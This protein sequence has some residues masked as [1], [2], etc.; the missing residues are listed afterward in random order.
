[1]GT[2]INPGNEAFK[3]IRNG[4]Y[5]DKSGLIKCVN[6]S[7]D[8][9]NKLTCVSRSRRF[10]KSLA[11]QMLCAYYDR[12]VDSESLFYDLEISKS[13]DYHKY[14]NKYDVIYLDISGFISE[15][16]SDREEITHISRRIKDSIRAELMVMDAEIPPE[17]DVN[18]GL[19]WYCRKTGRK[20]IFI[21]DEWDAVIREARKDIQTQDSY[22]GL[23][24]GWFKNGNFTPYAVAAAYMTGILPIKKDGSQSAIS[25]FREYTMTDP[26]IME[27]YTGFLQNEVDNIC[28]RYGVSAEDMKNWYDGYEFG[29]SGA[30]YNPNSVLLAANSGIYESYWQRT[31]AS[32]NLYE[33][34]SIN[35]D[36][37]QDEIARLI[38]GEEPEIDISGFCNDIDNFRSIDDVLT[39]MVH[40]GYLAY[41]RVNRTVRIPNREINSE[42]NNLIRHPGKA[43][44]AELVR[45]SDQ[46]LRDTVNGDENAVAEAIDRVRESEYAPTYYNNEQALRYV[47]KFAYIT[48]V[49]Q[50]MKIEELPSGKGIADVAFLP[51]R[52]SAD[53][54][55]IIE[56]KW[57]KMADAAIS[58]IKDKNYPECIRDYGGELLLVGINYDSRA[59]KHSCKIEKL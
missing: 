26:G 57:D 6:D 55:M 19:L 35:I 31:S 58:Q 24:R 14:I 48:C 38:S 30:V 18:D 44:L 37:L 40:L 41:D 28:K 1:M 59:K 15:M 12:T 56:L 50:Y 46:L 32:D 16:K 4:E 43:R 2:Y 11:A 3:V 27:P 25:E 7:I 13:P 34:I 51:K 20:I 17:L 10:G 39:L 42:F 47:I 45:L 33:W 29:R 52:N 8:T 53:P 36:G 49:D 23:L 22:L 5:I 21:I 9:L 54:A